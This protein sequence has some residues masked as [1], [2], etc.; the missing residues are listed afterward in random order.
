M[1]NLTQELRLRAGGDDGE[2]EDIG[3][4]ITVSMAENLRGMLPLSI[5]MSVKKR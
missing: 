4:L 5:L 2:V 3:D 1:N